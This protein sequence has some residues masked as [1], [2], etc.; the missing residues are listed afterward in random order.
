M[1]RLSILVPVL[2]GL[3]ALFASCG[4]DEETGILALAF[5]LD[6]ESPILSAYIGDPTED[7]LLLPA[8]RYYIEALDEND[9]AISLGAVEVEDGAFVAFP[10]SFDAA[11]GVADAER[12]ESLKTVTNFLI[13]FELSE[14]VFLEAIT[15][16][17]SEFPFDPA[18]EPD[19]A[20]VQELLDLY[21]EMAAQEGAVAAA[22]SEIEARAEVSSGTDTLYVRSPWGPAP[23]LTDVAKKKLNDWI[24]STF[25]YFRNA[26]VVRNRKR[27]LQIAEQIPEDKREGIFSKMSSDKQGDAA[28]FDDWLD[29]VRTDDDFV[30]RQG[31]GIYHELDGLDH[32]AVVDSGNS[33]INV[34]AEEGPEAAKYATDKVVEAYKSVPVVGKLIDTTEKAMEWEEYAKKLAKDLGGTLDETGRAYL[35]KQLEEKIKD[36]LKERAVNL[37]SLTDTGIDKLAEYFAKKAVNALPKLPSSLMPAATVGPGASPAVPTPR[38]TPGGTPSASPVPSLE[39]S[40]EA[41]PT[42]EETEAPAGDLSW[43]DGYVQGIANEWVARGYTGDVTPYMNALSQCLVNAVLDGAT[44]E[45]AKADC[46]PWLYAPS[47]PEASATP[48]PSPSPSPSPQPTPSP[49]PTGQEVTAEGTYT[50]T[51]GKVK[52]NT[53]WLKFDPAGGTVTGEGHLL[54]EEVPSLEC[55][56]GIDDSRFYYTGTYDAT[57]KTFEGT[58]YV[59]SGGSQ[60]AP[61][62]D[63]HGCTCQVF[64]REGVTEDLP[65]E[66]TLEDGVVRSTV[67]A[68]FVLTVQG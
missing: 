10:P 37:P 36:D 4:G 46:P 64:P 33:A 7:P 56:P 47:L 34:L 40:P 50:Y 45:Q 68:Q 65:W 20:S 63:E 51:Y 48:T 25:S 49:S 62:C 18:V 15:G 27:I 1:K 30:R 9:V 42:A 21:A 57:S 59:V 16:G 38:A 41:I 32:E 44:E 67:G 28:N 17:F 12:A 11:G 23:G 53:I 3:A 8:G 66:A 39:P 13:D 61:V 24:N 52:N 22:F 2:A 31:A 14:L 43:I 58:Y 55:G 54:L 26:T 35:Q 19:A 6:G 5:R 29:K 60:E